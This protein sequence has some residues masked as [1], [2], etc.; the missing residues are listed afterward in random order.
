MNYDELNIE[1]EVN[2]VAKAVES[3]NFRQAT[4]KESME[5]RVAA[6]SDIV[7]EMQDIIKNDKELVSV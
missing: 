5:V 7:H 4:K 3:G 1:N 6:L 2:S